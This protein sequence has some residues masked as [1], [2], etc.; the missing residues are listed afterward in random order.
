[1]GIFQ[2]NLSKLGKIKSSRIF[3]FLTFFIIS[4][5]KIYHFSLKRCQNLSFFTKNGQKSGKISQF[6]PISL[7]FQ[8]KC[9]G[10]WEY[11]NFPRVYKKRY[12]YAHSRVFYYWGLGK[13]LNLKE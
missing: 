12:L 6:G 11:A 3:I 8:P 9:G 10:F 1:M 13:Y 5:T 2:E 7:V 4:A